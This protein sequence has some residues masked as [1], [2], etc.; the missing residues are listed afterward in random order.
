M[1]K[2]MLINPPMSLEHRYG[3]GISKIG[4]V[5]PPL[6]LAYLGAM[7]EKHKHKVKI[8]DTQLFN[9][10]IKKTVEECKKFSPDIIGIYTLTSSFKLVVKLSKELKKNLNVKIAIGGAHPTIEPIQA[11]KKNDID[12]SISGEGEFTFTELLSELEK[13]NP[14]FL[15]VKG[16]AFKHKGKI[17][18][19]GAKPP[20]KNLDE[21]PFPA[22]HLLKM[23][24][25]K[26][27]PNHYKELP[28]TTM[29]ASRGCPYACSFCSSSRIWKQ[30]YRT[31]SV[32]NVIEEI[33]LL[34]KEYGTKD[35]GFWDDLWGVNPKW[36]EEF[37]DELKKSNLNISWSC[38]LR[39]D[40][41]NKDLLKKM[42]DAGCWCIFY[43][44]ESLDQDILDAINKKVSSRQI[45]KALEWTKEAGIEIRANFILAL[46]RETPQKVKKML[47]EL[48]KIDM[49]YV[50]FNILTPYPGTQL[51]DEIK[52]GK[53]GIMKEDK[54]KMTGYYVTFVPSGYKNEKEVEKIKKYAY[55]KYY[56]RPN[57]ILK[58]I[59]SI[60]SF[61]DLT[62][63]I[64][65]AI[66]IF[67]I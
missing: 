15:K 49:E 46:P 21:V 63:Y 4:T 19:N 61:N 18:Y 59:S 43:G 60:R 40:S 38:E 11:L 28:Y 44:I 31:R 50:K 8:L 14:D 13:K 55:R 26:P 3:K 17:I 36:V 23:N 20:I 67:S 42:A 7:L 10:G 24:L 12:F 56:L 2:V 45:I 1:F 35:I 54:T 48:V 62:R 22:R 30:L 57:Y 33:K 6:G 65:G 41:A 64:K 25:Y 53:W 32:K 16:I 9:F 58:R 34:K 51:Y 27:S 66:A 39:V 47:R 5:L 52:Q 37:C 29:T